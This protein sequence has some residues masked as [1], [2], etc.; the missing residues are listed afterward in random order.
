MSPVVF[1]SCLLIIACSDAATTKKQ[2]VTRYST[3]KVETRQDVSYCST[4]L[5]NNLPSHCNLS[6]LFGRISNISVHDVLTDAKLDALN[7]TYSRICVPECLDPIEKFYRC[8]IKSNNTYDFRVKLLRKGVCGQERGEYCTVRYNRKYNG[9]NN[10][11][12]QLIR[13]CDITDSGI[14]CNSYYNPDCTEYVEM[15]SFRMG[16]CTEP[17]LGSDVR[18][19]SNVSVDEACTGVSSAT[20]LVAPVFLMLFVLVGF[21][22]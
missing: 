20:G 12:S 2:D 18:P 21:F 13:A 8:I 16:C 4:T 11:L 3:T 22:F 1:L 17:Y 6:M 15:F 14:P 9:N 10:F 19:C 7:S 5:N